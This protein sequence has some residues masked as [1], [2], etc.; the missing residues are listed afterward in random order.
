MKFKIFAVAMLISSGL[1]AQK[2]VKPPVVELQ[3]FK[4]N[5]TSLVVKANPLTLPF[6]YL[7]AGVEVRNQK[8]GWVLM[9]HSYIG[10]EA[11]IR[12]AVSANQYA[13]TNSFVR[14]EGA[15]RWY[16]QRQSYWR[17]NKERYTGVYLTAGFTNF[18]YTNDF[19]F[20]D[21]NFEYVFLSPLVEGARI[22]MILGADFGRT[23]NFAGP[24]SLVYW[25]TSWKIGY[26]IGNR[27]P[28][29]LYGIRF[30]YKAN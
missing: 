2:I 26:N 3:R 8:T 25:E 17:G 20:D 6:G 29:V 7:D 23:R 4:P 10:G 9:N 18:S 13:I 14:F 19:Y 24:E 16:R 12:T 22:D 15:H 21:V 28:Q 5:V 30:N 27:L 1:M 11:S